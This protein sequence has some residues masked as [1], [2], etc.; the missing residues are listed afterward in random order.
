MVCPHIHDIVGPDAAPVIIEAFSP[1]STSLYLSWDPPP[2]ELHRGILTGYRITY[3]IVAMDRSVQITTNTSIT[4]EDLNAF[5]SYQVSVSAGTVVGYSP[6]D[7][8]NIMTLD[9]SKTQCIFER[10]VTQLVNVVKLMLYYAILLLTG[11]PP[12]P[13]L[14]TV[15]S[16]TSRS[17]VVSWQ[18]DTSTIPITGYMVRVVAASTGQVIF[19]NENLSPNT[20]ML[21]LTDLQP[22]TDYQFLISSVNTAGTGEQVSTQFRTIIEGT[23]SM[24]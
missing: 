19:S 21:T 4:L 2:P 9:D 24:L 16:L 20:L 7:T 5:T 11:S 10:S 15:T 12:T 22:T 6:E 17:V 18:I 13:T 3:K 23:F 1:S 14:L 8:I